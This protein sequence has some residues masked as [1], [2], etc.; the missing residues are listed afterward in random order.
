MTPDPATLASLP[1]PQTKA[2]LLARI[3]PARAALE[4]TI[5]SLTAAQI[6]TPGPAGWSVKDHLAHLATWEQMIVAHLRDGSDHAVV[7]MDAA[8]Y[9]VVGLADLNEVIFR[10]H[11]GRDAANVLRD[12]RRSHAQVM[13][14]L[15]ELDE[16]AFWMPYW[17]DDPS[18]RSVMEKVAGDTYKHDLEH[19]CWIEELVAS[20]RPGSIR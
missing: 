4:Q 10:R 8:A 1:T 9:A 12:F 13:A 14:L 17:Q 20:L 16:V 18:G 11:R 5:A 6:R 3:P 7:G 19:R 15:A 2:E